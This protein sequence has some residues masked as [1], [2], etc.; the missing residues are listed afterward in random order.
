VINL[1]NISYAQREQIVDHIEHAE[2]LPGDWYNKE[3]DAW[4]IEVDQDEI[5]GWTYMDNFDMHAFLL[6]IGVNDDDVE[7]RH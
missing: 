2:Q 6:M 4:A 7:W 1:D 5:S 3:E